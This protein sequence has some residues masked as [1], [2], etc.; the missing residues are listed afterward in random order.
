MTPIDAAIAAAQAAPDDDAAQRALLA[1]L[2]GSELY[3]LLASEPTDTT[4]S[5]RLFDLET[6]AVALVFDRE[7][8]LADFAGPAPYAAM[9][10]RELVGLLQGQGIGIA[11]NLGASQETILPPEAL[12]WLQEAEVSQEL[13]GEMPVAVYPPEGVEEEVLPQLE[14]RLASAEGL[15]K[16]AV[17]VTA[18]YADGRRGPCLILIDALVSAEGDLA[19]YIGDAMAIMGRAGGALDVAFVEAATEAAERVRAAGLV[20]DLPEPP[21]PATGLPD[22]SK[23]PRLR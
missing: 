2:A 1:V 13:T 15:A 12:D 16:Q 23:P 14:A 18:E 10:G 4:I 22:P 19:R 8:R 6:G 5:P 9:T 3:L 17:L 20:I 11:V 7:D 21:K